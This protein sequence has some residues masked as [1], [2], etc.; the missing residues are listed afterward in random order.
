MT[1]EIETKKATLNEGGLANFTG[2][3]Q[4]YQHWLGKCLYTDGAKYVAD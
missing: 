1:T 2:S 3:E 4:W